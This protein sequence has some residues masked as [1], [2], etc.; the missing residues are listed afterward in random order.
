MAANHF[1]FENLNPFLS[2]AHRQ[3]RVGYCSIRNRLGMRIIVAWVTGINFLGTRARE[4]GFWIREMSVSIKG[5]K[6][7]GWGKVGIGVG[8]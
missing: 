2:I 1:L 5:K 4:F 6:I 7:L 3:S 8:G